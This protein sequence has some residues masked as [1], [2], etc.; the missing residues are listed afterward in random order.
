MF[1]KTKK[2]K[3]VRNNSGYRTHTLNKAKRVI[4]EMRM[5]KEIKNENEDGKENEWCLKKIL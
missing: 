1:P 2:K 5:M 3:R 4:K